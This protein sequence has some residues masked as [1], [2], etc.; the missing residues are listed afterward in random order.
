MKKKF[1]KLFSGLTIL[2]ILASQT[3]LG[4][5][6]G[7]IPTASAAITSVTVASPNTAVT[8]NGIHNITWSTNPAMDA[9]LVDIK[10]CVSDTCAGEI[11]E[12]SSAY[13]LIAA[14]ETN[15]GTYS[16]N[17]TGVVD[18]ISSYK[19]RVMAHD[20]RF[21]WDDSDTF[22]TIDNTYPSI[23]F[24][25]NVEEGPVS[26]DTITPS[27]GDATVMKW[28]Y[29]T[30]TTCSIT[31]SDYSYTNANSMNQNNETNNTKYICM[32]ATDAVGNYTTLASSNPIHIDSTVPS[33]TITDNIV[34]WPTT[35]E[36]FA[37]TGTDTHLS[38][39]KYGYV[40]S[41]WAC[42]TSVDT[43]EFTTYTGITINIANESNNGNYVCFYAADSAGN[44]NVVASAYPINLDITDPSI[45]ITDNIVA[46]PTTSES[47]AATITETNLSVSKYW[48]IATTWACTTWADTSS[49]TSY[50][51]ENTVDIT[52]QS[53]NNNYV[54]FFTQDAVGHKTV[55]VSTNKV[56]LDITDPTIPS[57][58]LTS[59][60]GWLYRT[61]WS[62][63]AITWD[64]GSISDT[65]ILANPITLLYSIN[66]GSSWTTIA[67]NEANDWTYSWTTPSINNNVL[68]MI[69]ATDSVG[70]YAS[71][72][73][74][75]S[76]IIDSTPPTV[77]SIVATPNPWSGTVNVTVYFTEAL[78]WIY[79]SQPPTVALFDWSDRAVTAVSDGTHTNG[80]ITATPT[81]WEWTIDVSWRTNGTL[82]FKVSWARDNALN[83]MVANNSGWSVV[84]DTVWPQMDYWGF[85]QGT[86]N[87]R[88]H[89]Y[90]DFSDVTTSVVSE[91]YWFSSDATCNWS[92]SYPYTF[93]DD[94]YITWNHYTDYLCLKAVDSVGN[95]I[96]TGWRH[97]YVDNTP[98]N[99]TTSTL[100]SPTA[101]YIF[102]PGSDNRNITWNSGEITDDNL[103]W[104]ITLSYSTNGSDWSTIASGLVNNGLY[105]RTIPEINSQSVIVKITAADRVGN[106]S[107]DTS[108]NVFTIDS[109]HPATT[110]SNIV[111]G[112][113]IAW[114]ARP[115]SFA[116][117]DN[118]GINRVYL[119]YDNVNNTNKSQAEYFAF[120]AAPSSTTTALVTT[121][122]LDTTA[123][124]DGIW[125][126]YSLAGDMASN[127]T[128][129]TITPVII[130]NTK[131]VIKDSHLD[132]NTA[133]ATSATLAWVA[134]HGSLN[135]TQ[136]EYFID[137]IGTNGSGGSLDL[138]T[139]TTNRAF[140]SSIDVSNK[141]L[142]IH[143]IY[144]HAMNSEWVRGTWYAEY[145]F[146]KIAASD[147]TP[148]TITYSTGTA[149]QTTFAV[150][151]SSNESWSARVKYGP[152]SSYGNYTTD[153]T[154]TWGVDKTI[155]LA[156]LTCGITYHYGIFAKDAANN[157]W[158]RADAT[159]TTT[160][161]D[162]APDIVNLFMSN[163]TDNSA[164]INWA[165]DL[166]GTAK[167]RIKTNI[168]SFTSW[169][170]L[171]DPQN[172][173]SL[174]ANTSYIIEIRVGVEGNYTTDTVSFATATD[175]G[176]IIIN[177]IN[178][179]LD[180]STPTAWGWY[181]SGYH[182][183]FNI[184]VNNILRNI[185][186]FKL[187][188]RSNSLTTMEVANN[189]KVFASKDGVATYDAAGSSG[190]LTAAD[191][192][193]SDL[194]ISHID[195]NLNAWG[196]QVVLDMFYKI[197]TWAQ[198]IFST[199]YGI[200][201]TW[202][203]WDGEPG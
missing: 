111:S 117:T 150:T 116:T 1:K 69:T 201:A 60:N 21:K 157:E 37:A 161:C 78:A 175:S 136:V 192:Y 124:E 170:S 193:S 138:W 52:N 149:G 197:P 123:L 68:V 147:T 126:I 185:L 10:Y 8:R 146:T 30:G 82:Y 88:D 189:T 38:T 179:I 45:S 154:V 140:A 3:P 153:Y 172:I 22:F 114:S 148:P 173:T 99:I 167:Y 127:S 63:H 66:G 182:F 42:T 160:A 178:R 92:D 169:N 56:N 151:F 93:T 71:D 87:T 24:T 110:I 102:W 67:S 64:S 168:S 133:V 90:I 120:G 166:P 29:S 28:M 62:I 70:N 188:N 84:V 16:R 15:D 125:Y 4:S 41:A 105:N 77:S 158:S 155:T 65:N 95:T 196:H 181:A 13:I 72:T 79:I 180:G 19:I 27:R 199:S 164:T 26:S 12:N 119:Y 23:S 130:D 156:W 177:S 187:A 85:A 174:S 131:P 91:K 80:F 191:T 51:S 104:W 83:T 81:I 32:Y 98:P 74:D 47:F 86:R 184:T 152:T 115:I 96:Y 55:A 48:Y 89:V 141:A 176:S 106:T 145:V 43:A 94:F 122:A 200:Q 57:N 134:T 54:C 6:L 39:F 34:A 61:W 194:D 49:W 113:V 143:R 5:L 121:G 129:S 159:F 109:G 25:Q 183:R 17:T 118:Y 100:T 162:S 35:S 2:V 203:Y 103:T 186:N 139:G 163:I 101:T 36:S 33:I 31:G 135:I 202:I 137:T 107:S 53:H 165:A 7:T 20:N 58:T 195:G 18:G 73:S 171:G 11:N 75:T 142:G 198:G 46:W 128:N 132:F 14:N 50:T 40:G 112:Q 9:G 144:V 108:N 190:T 44:K 97:L 59:P 76:F